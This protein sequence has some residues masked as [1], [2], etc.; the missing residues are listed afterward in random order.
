MRLL[1][2]IYCL[3]N[4]CDDL[5]KERMVWMIWKVNCDQF[6]GSVTGKLFVFAAYP[7]AIASESTIDI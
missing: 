7:K 6:S 4:N 3:Q 1:S 2:S 5:A